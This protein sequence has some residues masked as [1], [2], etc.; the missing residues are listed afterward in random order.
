[1]EHKTV[2]CHMTE[3][4]GQKFQD[5]LEFARV[6]ETRCNLLNFASF[7]TLQQ[8]CSCDKREGGLALQNTALRF[9]CQM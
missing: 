1:M 2:L 5:M 7:D 3:C 6:S 9:P 8:E 4:A